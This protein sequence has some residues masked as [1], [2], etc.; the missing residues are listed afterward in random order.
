MRTCNLWPGRDTDS[1]LV[2]M[3][4]TRDEK[5]I[6]E[7]MAPDAHLFHPVLGH[8]HTGLK[9]VCTFVGSQKY[10]PVRSLS[11]SEF[12]LSILET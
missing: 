3:W 1:M 12:D 10:D 7:C 6:D 8:T 4:E 9:E 5:M 2:Q 11:T